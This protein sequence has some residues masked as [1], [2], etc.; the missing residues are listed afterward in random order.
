MV[1]LLMRNA[2]APIDREEAA[3]QGKAAANAGISPT[4]ALV[5]AGL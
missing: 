3:W 5:E 4:H 2:T 1:V